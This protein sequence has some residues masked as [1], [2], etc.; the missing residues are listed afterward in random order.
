MKVVKPTIEEKDF[1][2]TPIAAQEGIETI[3]IGLADNL[4]PSDHLGLVEFYTGTVG[5]LIAVDYVANANDV[6]VVEENPI[7][8]EMEPSTANII[9]NKMKMVGT[10]FKSLDTRILRT[11]LRG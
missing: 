6:N 9:D 8:G 2:P 10:D 3:G 11:N 1:V 4:E 7:P 5:Q